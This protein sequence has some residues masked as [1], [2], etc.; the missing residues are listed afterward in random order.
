M[1][2]H[3]A[4]LNS[5]I[6]GRYNPDHLSRLEHSFTLSRHTVSTTALPEEI[7]AVVE[8]AECIIISVSPML[9]RKVLENLP[10]LSLVVRHGVGCD[11]V[12][13]EAATDLGIPVGRIENTIEREA[14]AEHTIALMLSASRCI[15]P[16][17]EVIKQDRWDERRT[18][19][20]VELRDLTVGIIGL[21]S[22]GGRVSEILSFGFGAR[23]LAYDP[24]V[25]PEEF[26]KRGAM[27][28]ELEELLRQSQVLTLHC[29][30]TDT[31]Y[32]ILSRSRLEALSPG[33]LIVNTARGA[34]VDEEA[35]ASLARSGHLRY[36]TDVVV[37]TRSDSRHHLVGVPGV[38]VTP[39]I[40]AYTSRSLEA[41][42]RMVVKSVEN[43]FLKGSYPPVLANPLVVERRK[44][45]RCSPE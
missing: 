16:G 22:I 34:L 1:K 9:S 19:V 44:A 20:G 21:G 11:N 41:M 4:I 35:L 43:W 23:V 24:F 7:R 25:A 31:T 12:D 32:Q 36:A 27:A 10:K 14:V 3:I 5:S 26:S 29:S 30:L 8:D 33:T 17:T 42:G 13:L 37:G 2:R 28:V 38:I 40:A 18:L 45:L 15:V 39:H 6:F